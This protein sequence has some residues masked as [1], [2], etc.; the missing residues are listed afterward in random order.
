MYQT[1]KKTIKCTEKS[2]LVSQ[3]YRLNIL[4]KISDRSW[5]KEMKMT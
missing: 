5:Q 2:C 3:N 4:V 1:V